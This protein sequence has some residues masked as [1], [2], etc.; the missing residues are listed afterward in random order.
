M[1]LSHQAEEG[2]WWYTLEANETI[3]AGVIQL[4]NTI[5]AVDP[6]VQE[7][8]ARRILSQQKSDG[9]WAIYYGGPSDLSTTIECYFALRLAGRQPEDPALAR[10]RAFI[11]SNGG[12]TKMRAFSRIHLALFGLVP[13]SACPSMPVWFMLLPAWCGVS[14]YEFSSWA[15]ASI[16]PLLLIDAVKPVRALPFTL[17][18]LYSE[19]RELRILK[20]ERIFEFPKAKKGFSLQ[21]FFLWFDK[22]LKRL[23]RL[24]WHPG[25]KTAIKKAEQWTRDHIARTEDIYP[26]MAYAVL[27]LSALGYPNDDPTI[28]KALNG[29][30]K[31]QQKDGEMIHQQCCISPNWDT[32]WAGFALLEAGVKPDHPA[33][34]KAARYMISKEVKDFRGDWA[35]KNP[36]GTAGGWSF[37]FENDYF[38]DVDDTIEALHLLRRADLPESETCGPIQRG[39]AWMLSMQSNNGGWAAFDKNNVSQWVNKIPFSDHG[40]CLDPPTPDITGRMIELLASFGYQRSEPYIQR[41][42]KFL[43][44]TQEPDG[45]WRGRWGVNYVYGTWCVLQGLRAIGEDRLSPAIRKAVRFLESIQNKDGGWGESCLSDERG[46][47]VALGR[48]TASQT[49]WAILALLAVGERDGLSVHRGVQWLVDHQTADG[50]WEEREFTGTGFPGHFYIRYHGYRSYFPTLAL[51][52]YFRLRPSGS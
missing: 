37:E 38:P 44:R 46:A 33:I 28:Q 18:E 30:K 15:R 50:G 3:G 41:A 52:R 35:V 17:D 42:L 8:L 19:P 31:F 13:W 45:S 32:P 12:L 27:A 43:E 1:L 5:G 24:P 10:A 40:A 14:I 34:L 21:S 39:L 29:L 2:Y 7:G 11:V 36:K 6:E 48:S 47:Y 4:M 51:G 23:E 16:V 49:A 26:A 20:G 22:I 9:A 25:R